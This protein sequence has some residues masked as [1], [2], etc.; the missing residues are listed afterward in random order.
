MDNILIIGLGAL[1]KAFLEVVK[2]EKIH[3]EKIT[4]IDPKP[5]EPWVQQMYPQLEYK[6]IGLN[7]RNMSK[8]LTPLL[9]VSKKPFVFDLSVDVDCI[10]II[11]LC[12]KFDCV[13]LNTSIE[14]WADKTPWILKTSPKDLYD[15]SLYKRQIEVENLL[16][17]KKTSTI[18]TNH[19]QN[20]G[21]VS[22]YVKR[23]LID[24]AKKHGTKDDKQL[25]KG[26]DS[27][28]IK[29]I[30]FCKL[31][32]SLGLE[33][34]HIS[35]LDTQTFYTKFEKDHFYST[36]SA[37]GFIA[38]SLDPVQMGWGSNRP[39]DEGFRPREGEGNVRIF[40]VRGMDAMCK[41]VVLG[42]DGN[43]LEINGMLIPHAE[44][45]TISSFLTDG[46]Y[47]PS[48]FYVYQPSSLAFESLKQLRD[49]E[50]H[51][52]PHEKCHVMTNDEVRSGFD[53]V[54]TL[55]L[56]KNGKTHWCGSVVDCE[57]SRK[58]GFKHSNPTIVQVA[59][60]VWSATKWLQ[61]HKHSG[62]SEPEELNFNKIL[63]FAM[64]YLGNFY[65]KTL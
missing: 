15:R 18:L 65:S 61:T 28:K 50:Y 39:R 4:A 19:G 49:K 51:P 37:V 55:L 30:E 6:Q 23:G 58:L 21:M 62:Y 22:S 10:P 53:S 63:E 13:Y 12:K 52:P 41:S 43:V 27:G 17:H 33:E 38:E 47:C 14:S 11:K 54:G 59:A 48:V 5:Y 20:P 42:S 7:F 45:D 46:E 24:F 2:L 29:Q 26:L 60:G 31:A 35:E 44:A 3:I 36:W 40:P 64:P 25:A 9:N 1:A 16:G 8:I 57:F 56:F 34:I 32:K